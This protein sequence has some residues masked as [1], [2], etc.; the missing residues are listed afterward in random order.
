[1][2]HARKKKINISNYLTLELF[3]CH[4]LFVLLIYF[5]SLDYSSKR[6]IYILYNFNRNRVK[7]IICS[8]V[9]FVFPKYIDISC[10]NKKVSAAVNMMYSFKNCSVC[11]WFKDYILHFLPYFRIAPLGI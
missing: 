1:M 11:L 4:L 2:P 7:Y 8:N 3:V 10:E 5:K 6:V 9:L